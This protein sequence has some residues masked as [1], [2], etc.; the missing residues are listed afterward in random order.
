VVLL[1]CCL[2]A[3]AGLQSVLLSLPVRKQV[4][5]SAATLA[6]VLFGAWQGPQ[7]L[8][9]VTPRAIDHWLDQQPGNAPIM[10]FPLAEALSGPALFYTDIHGRP[11][12]AGYGTYLPLLYRD[13]HPA[14]TTFPSDESLDLL[15]EWGVEYVLVSDWALDYDDS[16]DP[17]TILAQ[18]RLEPLIT[19]DGVSAYRLRLSAN[20]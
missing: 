20:G 19:L 7:M 17:A 6:L 18:P 10:E 13:R 1:G 3:A 16:I 14:L 5:W 2:L 11:L 9:P 15:T 8:I 12:T 4:I